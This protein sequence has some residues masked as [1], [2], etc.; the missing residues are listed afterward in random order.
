MFKVQFEKKATRLLPRKTA[1]QP[2]APVGVKAVL[3]NQEPACRMEASVSLYKHWLEWGKPRVLR[4]LPLAELPSWGK[5]QVGM[6]LKR[7]KPAVS[8]LDSTPAT[9][10]ATAL[11]KLLNLLPQFPQQ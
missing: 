5:H 3:C 6:M 9:P 11:G 2:P 1:S 7:T 4:P 8:H 10:P